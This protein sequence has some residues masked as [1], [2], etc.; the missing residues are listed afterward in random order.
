MKK[1]RID[2]NEVVFVNLDGENVPFQEGSVCKVFGNGIFVNNPTIEM[3]DISRKIHKGEAVEVLENE[4]LMMI[5][6]NDQ[7]TS[8]NR[9]L[10]NGI[11]QYLTN[12]LETFKTTDDGNSN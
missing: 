2:I 12:K 11:N 6:I 5:H 9:F 10:K 8:Y 7:L 3:E 4:L 1:V